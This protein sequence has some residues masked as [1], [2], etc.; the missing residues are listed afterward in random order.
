MGEAWLPEADRVCLD[1]EA[2]K[3]WMPWEA[4]QRKLSHLLE[5]VGLFPERYRLKEAPR[6]E[7]L[8]RLLA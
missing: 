8:E 1:W 6:V 5:P 4:V 3:T 2:G 7:V